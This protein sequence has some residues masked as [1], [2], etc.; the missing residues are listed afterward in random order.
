MICFTLI[1]CS[2]L[3][4]WVNWLWF[5]MANAMSILIQMAAYNNVPMIVAYSHCA[6]GSVFLS[7]F[8]AYHP[9]CIGVVTALIVISPR[10]CFTIFC[11]YAACEIVIVFSSL[12]LFISIPTSNLS[13]PKS[14]IWNLN[15]NIS[16]ILSVSS[17]HI[18]IPNRS[19]T[20]AVIIWGLSFVFQKYTQCS[21][22]NL[23]KP[24]FSSMAVNFWCHTCPACFSPYIAFLNLNTLPVLSLSPS[25]WFI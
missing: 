4:F 20:H 22:Y 11:M 10:Y 19:S 15:S 7:L 2:W 16:L 14:V 5:C 8:I 18:P 25:G 13:S 1:Q 24:Y 23:L 6:C 3:G 17:L 21:T 12:F 9:G